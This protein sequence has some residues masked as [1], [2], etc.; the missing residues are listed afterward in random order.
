MPH[1]TKHVWGYRPRTLPEFE[2]G[3]HSP[4]PPPPTVK[5]DIQVVIVTVI[6]ISNNSKSNSDSNSINN[7]PL[8]NKLKLDLLNAHTC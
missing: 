8:F 6:T 2:S 1:K 4:T 5:V 3:P 7:N